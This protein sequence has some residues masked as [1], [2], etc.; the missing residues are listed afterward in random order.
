ML[1]L[2]FLDRKI[3]SAG[4]LPSNE[5]SIHTKKSRGRS[6]KGRRVKKSRNYSKFFQ[7]NCHIAHVN[8]VNQ[9]NVNMAVFGDLSG[10]SQT[11]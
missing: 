6:G 5:R 8:T 9:S 11:L 2:S 3:L 4:P 1:N 10:K 7:P